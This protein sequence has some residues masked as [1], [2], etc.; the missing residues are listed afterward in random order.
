MR[1]MVG[2]APQT[3]SLTTPFN[4]CSAAPAQPA[5][6][7]LSS[8]RRREP[9]SRLARS[10]WLERNQQFGGAHRPLSVPCQRHLVVLDPDEMLGQGS[11]RRTGLDEPSDRPR[12][13]VVLMLRGRRRCR[14]GPSDAGACRGL[15][16][17]SYL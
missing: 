5:R 10:L 7:Q 14:W 13:R 3:L 4:R 1:S 6:Q 12:I 9:N 15:G 8:P 2:G 11:H 17:P 16:P